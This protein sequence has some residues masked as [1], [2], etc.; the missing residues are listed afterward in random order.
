MFKIGKLFHLTHVV[1][2]L[3]A[4]DRWYDDVFSVTRFYNGYEELAGRNASLIAIGDVIMEPMMPARVENFKNP[5]VKR[6][7]ERFG[8]HFH[9]SWPSPGFS[10]RQAASA[11]TGRR[12]HHHPRAGSSLWDGSGLYPAHAPKRSTVKLV[13][14]DL[15]E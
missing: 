2:D 5:S 14:L 7:H 15:T 9:R 3:E 10:E 13:Y 11:R 6:F 8:Q 4:V 12:R 1:D